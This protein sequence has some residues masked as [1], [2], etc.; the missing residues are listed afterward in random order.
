MEGLKPIPDDSDDILHLID[1]V[2]G[3]CSLFSLLKLFSLFG[4]EDGPINVMAVSPEDLD[5]N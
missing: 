3:L 5:L 2:Y 4:F 1:T